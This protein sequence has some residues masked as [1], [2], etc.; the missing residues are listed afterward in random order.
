MDMDSIFVGFY[1]SGIQIARRNSQVQF[2]DLSSYNFFCYVFVF[3][4]IVL[5]ENF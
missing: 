2:E 4:L 3:N 5:D 1:I